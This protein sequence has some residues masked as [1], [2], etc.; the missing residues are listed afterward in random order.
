MHLFCFYNIQPE[1]C[2]LN[3]DVISGSKIPT[4]ENAASVDEAAP[5]PPA[6]LTPI[7]SLCVTPLYFKV[8]K[9]FWDEGE[10]KQH[11]STADEGP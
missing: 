5:T 4:S 3:C 10:S 9:L 11:S 2:Q 1:S 6:T 8:H 7:S